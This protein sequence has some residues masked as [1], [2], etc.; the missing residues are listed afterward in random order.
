MPQ[1]RIMGDT[2]LLPNGGVLNPVVYSPDGAPGTRFRIQN[3]TTIPQHSQKIWCG[4]D[5]GAAIL[6]TFILDESKVVSTQLRERYAHWEL[7]VSSSSYLAPSGYC[8]LF[9]EHQ[10]NPSDQGIWVQIVEKL[11]SNH[12][13]RL[14]NCVSE[15]FGNSLN[16]Y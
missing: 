7:D 1:A 11:H 2:V 12:S 9:V 3:P 14:K 6:Y 15:R 5:G 13:L 10:Q 4:Y 8:L 16:E